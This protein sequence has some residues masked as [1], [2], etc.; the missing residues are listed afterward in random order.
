MIKYKLGDIV[1]LKEPQESKSGNLTDKVRIDQYRD[2]GYFVTSEY[3]DEWY[4]AEY[5]IEELVKK[6]SCPMCGRELEE[7]ENICGEKQ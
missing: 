2:G 5:E 6:A 4:V 3:L 7:S 1:K